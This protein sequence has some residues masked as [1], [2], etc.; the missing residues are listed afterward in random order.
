MARST[1]H[2]KPLAG[3]GKASVAASSQETGPVRPDVNP[4]EGRVRG[5]DGGARSVAFVDPSRPLPH[6][7]ERDFFFTGGSLRLARGR[8]SMIEAR[9][10]V[11]RS[12]ARGPAARVRR[13]TALVVTMV[14]AIPAALSAQQAQA[15]ADSV[16]HY[17]IPEVT[18]TVTRAETRRDAIPQSIALLSAADVD[19]TPA[20]EIADLLKKLAAVDVVQYPG[21]LSGV[22]IRGFRPQTS[23]INQRTLILVDGRHAGL[24]NLSLL[25]THAIERIEVLK[26]PA[27]SLYGSNAMGGAVNVITRRSAAA[28]GGNVTASYGSFSTSELRG[29]VGGAVNSEL[30]FDLG[31]AFFDRGGD[32]RV[33]G[34]NLFRDLLGGETLT[35]TMPDGTSTEITDAG[36]GEVRPFSQYSS[37]AGN[38]R[39]GYHFA[40]GI[41]IDARGEHFSADRVQGAGDIHS[42]FDSR[43]LKDV[44]RR[45]GEL[46]LSAA[47]G[48][49]R[50]TARVYTSEEDSDSFNV[51]E[52]DGGQA[53][54][55]SFRSLN[56]WR[57]AQ[58]QDV[59]DLADHSLTIGV[60]FSGARSES[61]RFLGV[62]QRGAPFSPN[63]ENRSIAGFGQAHLAFLEERIV[64]T[65][66]ARLDNVTF[67]VFETELLTTRIPDR[68]TTLVFNPSFGLQYRTAG[69]LRL[70]TSGGRAFVTPHAFEVAGRDERRIQGTGR[71]DLTE[72]NPD[73]R[74]ENSFTWDLGV[75]FLDRVRGLD[76]DFAYFRT[77]VRDR[78]V[79]QT[80]VPAGV[81]LTPA[82]DTIQS[83]TSYI[84]ADREEIR[85]FEGRL[86]Y[87]FGSSI[88]R[89][90]LLRLFANGTRILRADQIAGQEVLPSKNVADLTLSYGIEY[91]D[92]RRYSARLTG[93][94][95][96]ERLDTDWNAWPAEVAYPAFM[97]LDLAG[98]LRVT[99]RY[100]LALHVSNL[101]DEHYYEIRGFPLPGR[102]LRLSV[103]AN[104]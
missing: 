88:G 42:A 5:M 22:G 71:I 7:K 39:V 95:V 66:G 54:F 58:L 55:V 90:S 29:S 75:G 92:L 28:I 14:T 27:A 57:G 10:D 8:D 69:G 43:T 100:G 36:D 2:W 70:R 23:G 16:P 34:G 64:A 44:A 45:S 85:G 1:S 93:R 32:F 19:R 21:L 41:R 73:L 49:H 96:G 91:D 53:Q 59:L 30:D 62:D 84:N 60:D 17:L 81:E 56:R 82:G 103:S 33:G 11:L 35:Q 72:G 79:L 24:S 97:T 65:L 78:I 9:L 26:G 31:V 38:L 18:V 80:D 37:R 87:D 15:P 51:P 63:Y 50:V 99:D 86:S 20:E 98:N 77:D 4:F 101:T 12:D 40:P 74:P 25:P 76:L 89:G 46:G 6:R 3:S 67:E 68:A 52:S 47:F 102:M 104:F 48:V 61:E 94:Y 83:I 13:A